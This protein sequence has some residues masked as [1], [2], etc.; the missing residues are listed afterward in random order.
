MERFTTGA[1]VAIFAIITVVA[2]VLIFRFVNKG[3]ISK[4]GGYGVYV[5]LKDASGIAKMSQVKMAGIPVGQITDVRLDGDRARVDI[6][7]RGDVPLYDDATA[8]KVSSSLLG[9]FYMS[10]TP[11]TSGKRKLEDGDQ[12][13]FIIEAA[14]TDQ[15]LKD[16][17]EITKDVKKV[18]ESLAKSV[19]SDDGQANIEK[20][21]KNLAE[22]TEQLNEVVRENRGAIRSILAN[23]DQVTRDGKPEVIEILRNVRETTREVRELM[24]ANSGEGGDGGVAGAAGA[25]PGEVRQVIEKVNRAAS[26]LESALANVDRVT[27]RI[28]RGEGTIGRLSRDERLID[29]VEGAAEGINEYVGGIR[30]LRTVIG[31]R[32]DYQFLRSSVKSYVELRLQPREDK[33]YSIELI[34]DPRGLTRI[35]QT[36]VTTTNPNDP[37]YYREVRTVTTNSFRFSLQFAQ[38]FGPF[39][40]RFGIKE[41]TGG[42]GLD[43][44]L[45]DKRFEIRQ[46]LFGFGE[47]V[48]PRWRIGFGYEFVSRIWL[49][50]GVDDILS[51]DQRDY[52]V[53]LQLRF[54]DEDLKTILP[55][56]PSPG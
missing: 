46:D 43:V 55:F 15:I 8:A 54:D 32:S 4:D 3:A 56:A 42:I 6:R 28:D 51:G 1:K 31:L 5:I 14:T 34:S 37:A 17:A 40:G 19:G 52:F 2:G 49:L 36:N 20:T 39:T 21:L 12:V 41:S 7:M 22:A 48:L 11:G 25:K 50:G 44:A 53:G 18:T 23:V 30:R 16:V 26:S 10:L 29:E 35:E 24:A 13:R 9:E 27:G 33:Y 45:F 47:V 38:I